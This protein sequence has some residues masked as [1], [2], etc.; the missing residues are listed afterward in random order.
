MYTYNHC[1]KPNPPKVPKIK[2]YL[3]CDTPKL[4]DPLLSLTIPW[5]IDFTFAS[6]IYHLLQAKGLYRLCRDEL[7]SVATRFIANF[8]RPPTVT[9]L[10]GST[11]QV[12]IPGQKYSTCSQ[13]DPV[14]DY[15]HGKPCNVEVYFFGQG[16]NIGKYFAI[17]DAQFLESGNEILCRVKEIRSEADPD[18]PLSITFVAVLRYLAIPFRHKI[19]NTVMIPDALDQAD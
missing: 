3:D 11:I 8:P 5:S 1:T 19:T 10:D 9:D 13:C 16:D 14:V 7:D 4:C 2:A 6:D 17:L 12:S 18:L 15:N